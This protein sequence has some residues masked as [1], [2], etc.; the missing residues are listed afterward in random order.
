M[1]NSSLTTKL[2][3]VLLA[4]AV[5]AY[6]GFQAWNYFTSPELTTAVYTYRAERVL[7]LGGRVVRDEEVIDCSDP[8]VELTRAEGERVAKGQRVATVYQSADALES[9]REA[10]ALRAQLEQLKYAQNAARDAEAALRLDS[11]IES[12]I[13]A[14]RA[15]LANGSYTAAGSAAATLE[16]TVLRREYAY[17]GSTDL[18]DRIE[19]LEGEIA[20]ASRKAGSGSYAVTAPFAGSYSAVAD[21]YE[22]VL[23]PAAL[24]D[25]SPSAFEQAAPVR[26]SST[27]GKLIRG[28]RWYYAAV[29]SESDAAS[30]SAGQS[31]ELALSGVD[32]PLPVTVE[33][34]SRPENGRRLLVVS[35]NRY[36]NFVSMLRAQSAELILERYT[37]LRVPK[38]ALRVGEDQRLGVYCR[39]GRQAWFKPVELLYQ[40]E[41]YCLVAP[42]TIEATRDS[43]LIFYTL[44][45][46]DEVVVSA[47]N[48][49]NGK[50][51]EQS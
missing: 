18:G 46:G 12:G 4:L 13:V 27:V 5:L 17:R 10:D 33:S 20:A 30:I 25:M 14:L 45:A 24:A 2:V 36:L 22:S 40:G 51:L 19:R 6:F 39:I 47:D 50:V 42:G 7:A 8:L 49:Y 44:R 34:L 21:G 48:L 28:D 11:E 15:A 43:D 1:K 31:L 9:E 41:D 26:V 16:A 3:A 38:N 23:T 35:G 32:L 37:G 29:I